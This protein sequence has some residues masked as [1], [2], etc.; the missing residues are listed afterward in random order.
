MI[1]KALIR[2][3]G[4]TALISL[5]G[6][7]WSIPPLGGFLPGSTLPEQV[8]KG[9][10]K[11]QPTQT[12]SVAAPEAPQEES[13]EEKAL[14]EQAK[15]IKFQL[16]DIQ[17]EGNHVYSTSELSVL[18]R[19]KLHRTISVADLFGIVQSIT[20]YYRNNGYIL[21]RA[22]LPPQHV[23]NGEVKIQIIEGYIDRVDVGG[24]PRGARCQV[25]AFG[26]KIKQCPPLQLKRM[27][28]YLLLANELPMTQ[29]KSVLSPSK[30]HT[31]AADLTL[32]T[33]NRPI[34]GYV[35][36][37]N[38]GTR[39]IGPQQ[40][41]A[42]VALN[43]FAT[44]GDSLQLT[45]TKTPKGGELTNSDL[46]YSAAVNDEGVRGLVGATRTQTHPLFVLQPANIDGLSQNYYTN[47]NFPVIRS[48]SSSLTLRAGFNYLDSHVTTFE[49][50]LYTDHLR[51]LDVGATY[52]V[53]DRF[54]GSNLLSADIRQGLPIWGY[55]SD[56]NPATALTSRPG[57][58]AV[59]TKFAG[60]A[61]RLQVL[62][63]AFSLYGL[64]QGQWAGNALLA[65]EQFAYGG[66]QLGRGYDVAEII[67]DKG[68]AGTLELRYD[69]GFSRV[70]QDIQFYTFYDLGAIWNYNN[71][72]GVPR[73]VSGATTGIGARFYFTKYV[74]GNFM[75][76]QTLTKQVAAEELI[77]D[78]RRPRVFFSV[79]VALS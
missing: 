63:T 60:T 28:Y 61:S 27:E 20:N 69:K 67:G 15:K 64:I 31:G 68:L 57:G 41:T 78:G 48:R 13:K 11:Q 46:N 2:A 6:Q 21:S 55:T 32:M 10:A 36:Y 74:S 25:Q 56:T 18:Y 12:R 38:Y 40:M 22:V 30:T 54:L 51:N 65:S 52:N 79:V 34:S 72:G 39:Y 42:N 7:V 5:S 24:T 35:S 33:D 43:S 47:F 37:D 4:L 49:S 62:S 3:L 66:S 23:K 1:Q 16:K 71:I 77:G 19:D 17:L 70:I 59:Y 29:V 50:D 73:K 9:I 26:N 45:V 75:W 14:N 53:A 58:H 44:S 8:N 76:T